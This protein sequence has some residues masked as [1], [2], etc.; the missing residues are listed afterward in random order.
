MTVW[1][2][3][4]V[5]ASHRGE[6]VL[7]TS[8]RLDEIPKWFMDARLNFAENLLWCRSTEKVALVATGM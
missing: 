7:D 6:R 3:T 4:N 5:I 2:Y 1:E 8:K